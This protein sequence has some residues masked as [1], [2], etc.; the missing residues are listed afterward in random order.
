MILFFLPRASRRRKK[1]KKLINITYQT[2]EKFR[3]RGYL[4]DLT[5]YSVANICRAGTLCG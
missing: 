5:A 2:L 3:F 1:L 4:K